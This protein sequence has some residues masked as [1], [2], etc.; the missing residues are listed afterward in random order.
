MKTE[1]IEI[2]LHFTAKVS[3]C[4]VCG[5]KPI[6]TAEISERPFWLD[7]QMAFSDIV[8]RHSVKCVDCGLSAPIETWEA[9]AGKLE[10]P[11]SMKP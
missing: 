4:P 9:L 11:A 5:K 3:C 1:Q 10:V 7:M 8:E 2:N 6:I